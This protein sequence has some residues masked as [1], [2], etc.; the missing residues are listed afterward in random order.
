MITET[1]QLDNE[2]VPIDANTD[3][4]MAVIAEAQQL[5][6]IHYDNLMQS[7]GGH[8]D[9]SL[10]LDRL[11]LAIAN[12]TKLFKEEAPF[13]GDVTNVITASLSYANMFG[14][15]RP[16]IQDSVVSKKTNIPANLF[17]VNIA[18]SGNGKDASFNLG[19]EVLK[20]AE[21]LIYDARVLESEKVAKATAKKLSKQAQEKEGIKAEEIVPDDAG[22]EQY[23]K[24]ISAGI[25]KS[26]TVQGLLAEAELTEKSGK[27]G[28]LF[29][30][31]SELGN[32]LKNDGNIDG[33][34]Q[35]LAEGFDTGK[36]PEDL[37]KTKE[38][39][40]AAVEGLGMSFLA[41]TSPAPLMKDPK[42]VDKLKSIFG[43]YLGRRAFCT[44]T[45]LN[46]ATANLELTNNID[47]QVESMLDNTHKNVGTMDELSK[48]AKVAVNRVLNGV[49]LEKLT[50]TDDARRLYAKYYILNKSYRS[51]AYMK[52]EN[53]LSEGLLPELI[54]RHWKCIKLAGIWA[55]A[56]NTSVIDAKLMA[57]AIYFTEFVGKGLRQLMES[58]DLLPHERFIKAIEAKEITNSIRFDTMMKQGYI[59]KAEKG[60]IQT[61]LVGVNSALQGRA[62][63]QADFEKSTCTV[64][65][66]ESST[67]EYGVS[68]IKFNATDSKDYRKDKSFKGFKY[69]KYKLEDLTVLLKGDYAYSPF[70]FKDS[71]RSND[72]IISET[73]WLALD[74]DESELP[75]DVLHETYLAGTCHIIATSSDASNLHKFRLIVPIAQKIGADKNVYKYV[76]NR[77]AD[78][79]ML[80]LDPQSTVIS[81]PMFAYS[82]GTVLDNLKEHIKPM[83]VSGYLAD[84]ATNV[85]Q[86]YDNKPMT[87]PQKKKAQ[88][89]YLHDFE[90]KLSFV[91]NAP[92]G[93]GSIRLWQAGKDMQKAGLDFTSITTLLNKINSM[94]S[95]PMDRA[96]ISVICNQFK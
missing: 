95:H 17:V 60:Q 50:L 45:S 33:L 6:P 86:V 3:E 5:L 4:G 29:I 38:L 91:I 68:A 83:D 11:P 66:I 56:N 81:Q 51:L 77:V 13:L 48:E 28:N 44:I 74:I 27:Y 36:L 64:Q 87:A 10:D 23:L 67:G 1:Q 49:D 8:L 47:E 94:W 88:G 32:A 90:D 2:L 79:L 53:F 76:M 42:L 69:N 19:I 37:V 70:Q 57:S 9:D 59:F 58:I 93:T 85:Q 84:A 16:Y 39:K 96:R 26:A 52:D 15:F 46:D 20:E 54:N 35:I 43:S 34:I 30:I 22:W 75:M 25:F 63:V 40:V 62:I 14:K 80:T 61:F 71:R 12:L 31:I 24:P 18:D 21:A 92:H 78:E 7:I 55:L 65:V 73:N 89:E 72:N 41:H 82:G